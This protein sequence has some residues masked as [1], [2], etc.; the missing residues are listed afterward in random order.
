MYDQPVLVAAQIK[1]H[2]IVAD[3]IDR[4]AERS[5]DVVT[6]LP[7]GFARYCKP[8]ANR[9][10]CLRMTLPEL[11]Q[12]PASNHLHMAQCSMSPSW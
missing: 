3:E 12:C 2:S 4:R 11:A 6:V 5:L 1:D 10:F 9:I 8:S 7:P